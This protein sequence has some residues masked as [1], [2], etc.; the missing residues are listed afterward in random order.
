MS[1]IYR[2]WNKIVRQPSVHF[3]HPWC[4]KKTDFTNHLW[5][6]KENCLYKKSY[7]SYTVEYKQT[8]LGVWTDVGW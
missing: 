5:C 7:N 2:L 3:R 4:K 6:K 8:K 1:Q